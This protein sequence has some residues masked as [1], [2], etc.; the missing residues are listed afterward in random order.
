L[1]AE[2]SAVVFVQ[3]FFFF[4]FFFFFVNVFFFFFQAED[5]IRDVAV[6]G[7]Q[8][9]S[10]HQSILSKQNPENSSEWVLQILSSDNKL[11]FRTNGVDIVKSTTT[12]NDGNWNN[13]IITRVSGVFYLYLNSSQEDTATSSQNLT[14]SQVLRIGRRYSSYNG[15]FDGQISNVQ[16]FNSALSATEVETLYNYGSPIKT[17]A[18]IPQS[19]NLKAWYKLDAS[20]VYNSTTTEWS[21]DN[22]QNPSAYPSSLEFD[23]ASSDAITLGNTIGNGFTQITCS[24][25]ANI[26]TF[27]FNSINL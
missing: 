19:S 3:P 26:S 2:V 12:V 6:T 25:W 22:N 7:V 10:Q 4:F 16:I 17:L 24:I 5:G 1:L 11:C 27:R 9:S 15:Y 8:T 14:N 13:V 20:E 18:N 21:V 23:S